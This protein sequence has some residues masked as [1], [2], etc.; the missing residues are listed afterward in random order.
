[1][2]RKLS[3]AISAVWPALG[4][5]PASA[6]TFAATSCARR[7][8]GCARHRRVLTTCAVFWE[9]SFLGGHSDLDSVLF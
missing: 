1:M 4:A 8:E 6:S 9:K 2:F 5:I 3:A 7:K